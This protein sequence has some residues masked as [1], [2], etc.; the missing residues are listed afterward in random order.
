M[1]PTSSCSPSSVL[2]TRR[3]SKKTPLAAIN[4]RIETPDKANAQF[5]AGLRFQMSENDPD[6]PAMPLAGYL[7]GGPITS[8]ISDRIRNREGLSYG[9]NARIAGRDWTRNTEP[10]H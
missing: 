2:W 8:H 10:V 3:P 6:Y 9:A 1:A 5:E 7:F 4:Q